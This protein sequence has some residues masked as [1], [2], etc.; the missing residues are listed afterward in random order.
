[1][2]RGVRR[3]RAVVCLVLAIASLGIAVQPVS[4]ESRLTETRRKLRATRARLAVVRHDDA[5]LLA[6]IRQLGGQLSTVRVSL[7]RAEGLLA[8]VEAGIRGQER[9]LARLDAEKARRAQVVA[10]RARALYIMGAGM[11]AEALLA[12]D[13]I[14]E[15]VERSESLDQAMRFDRMLM[16]DLARISDQTR[17]TRAILAKQ[18]SRAAEVRTGI[19]ERAT[20]LADVISVKQVAESQLSNQISAYQQEVAALE[21][22]QARILA[23]IRSRQ[24]RSTGAIS[25]RGF[26]WPIRGPITSPYGPRWGGYHTGIDINCE[27]GD[28][29]VASKAGKVIASEWGGGYGRMIIIDHGNGVST[30]YAHNSALYVGQGRTVSRGE[31]IA[32]CGATGNASGDHLHF[33][34]RINGNHTNPRNFLP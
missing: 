25:R 30:L 22:E 14:S 13:S 15:F 2:T 11:Q 4:A 1:V 6:V 26:I 7:A 33:E 8:K 18:R 19:A 3:L 5:Q 20:E 34:V 23:I 21:R 32:S 16:D 9:R 10:E 29:I 27:T 24:S 28:R 17:K 12:S 31:R